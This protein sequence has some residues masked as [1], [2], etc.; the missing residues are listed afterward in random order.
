MVGGLA[1]DLADS[2]DPQ[3]N[4]LVAPADPEPTPLALQTF[5]PKLQRVGADL[6]W[7]LT[8]GGQTATSSASSAGRLAPLTAGRGGG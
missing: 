6:G 5:M 7:S 1:R 3:N 8:R 2:L 4:L